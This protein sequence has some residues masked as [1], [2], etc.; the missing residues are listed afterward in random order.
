MFRT[1][2]TILLAAGFLSLIGADAIIDPFA[3]DANIGAGGLILL[4][5]LAG[6]VGLIVLVVDVIVAANRRRRTISERS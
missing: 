4:G 1:I 3:A 6:S 2:G 5:R